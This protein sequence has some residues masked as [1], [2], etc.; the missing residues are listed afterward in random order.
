MSESSLFVHLNGAT[1]PVGE[2]RVSPLDR[3]FLYGDGVFE[4]MRCEDGQVLYWPEHRERLYRSASAL[5]IGLDARMEWKKV[6]RELVEVNE[7]KEGSARMKIVVTRGEDRPMGL[8]L[9][10]APTV[11]VAAEPY[12]PPGEKIYREGWR[13]RTHEEGY[14]P[15]LSRYKTLNYLYFMTAR[16]A[17]LDA[18][19]DEALILDSRG[20]VTETAAG[21]LLARTRNHWWAPVS[22]YQLPGIA[23]RQVVLML[24][25]A[26]QPIKFLP[27]SLEELLEAET[28]W[29]LN[30]LVGIM[31]VSHLDG[32]SFPRPAA[33]EAARYREAFLRQG[34][35]RQSKVDSL[36]E[37]G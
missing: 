27:A 37:N 15:P 9:G 2:A 5:R 12:K 22:H 34:M 20:N 16:Q 14:A 25:E 29:V 8:P 3:G 23:L 35:P 18:G 32:H 10:E 21:S 11:C 33:E 6:F 1:V 31:P 13:L 19:A 7:L 36:L 26:G 30:S 17:A 4:T 28:L 24:S